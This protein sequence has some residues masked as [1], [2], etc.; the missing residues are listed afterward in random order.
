MREREGQACHIS[1]GETIR[2]RRASRS[3][4]Q[5]YREQTFAR[6][7]STFLPAELSPRHF[8]FRNRSGPSVS[9]TEV[10]YGDC[11]GSDFEEHRAPLERQRTPIGQP[12]GQTSMASRLICSWSS[13]S[14]TAC[15]PFLAAA[16]SSH[17]DPGSRLPIVQHIH[18][19]RPVLPM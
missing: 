9:G 5:T 16:R 11:G 2:T 17:Y 7:V 13:C 19:V 14:F 1:R 6:A 10:D 12:R 18:Y 15:S 3:D 4:H 8:S